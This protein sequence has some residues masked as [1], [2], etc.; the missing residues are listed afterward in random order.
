MCIIDTNWY[1]LIFIDHDFHRSLYS[2]CGIPKIIK[3]S[4]PSH[5]VVPR[6]DVWEYWNPRVK[7]SAAS[8][9]PSCVDQLSMA[10]TE[11]VES[12]RLWSPPSDPASASRPAGLS[13]R[14]CGS[15]YVCLHP[16][17]GAKLLLRPWW[18][19]PHKIWHLKITP[20]H[21]VSSYSFPLKVGIFYCHIKLPALDLSEVFWAAVC[22]PISPENDWTTRICSMLFSSIYCTSETTTYVDGWLMML[23][24]SPH[25]QI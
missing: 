24:S 16:L 7:G 12:Y 2:F 15:C 10:K 19:K 21:L 14:L 9:K 25:L 13:R 20:S 8:H 1:S 3:H 6:P 17:G 18:L 4:H 5:G 23:L 11:T 22:W